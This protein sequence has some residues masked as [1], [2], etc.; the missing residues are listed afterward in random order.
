MLMMPQRDHFIGK[1][2][3]R[4]VCSS[5]YSYQVRSLEPRPPQTCIE[6]RLQICL[7]KGMAIVLLTW[8]SVDGFDWTLL[9]MCGKLIVFFF[10][11]VSTK[12]SAVMLV[13]VL[14]KRRKG[15]CYK[16]SRKGSVLWVI[17]SILNSTIMWHLTQVHKK[18]QIPESRVIN[19]LGYG[20]ESSLYHLWTVSLQ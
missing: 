8:Y 3:S 17:S 16:H 20:F 13:F 10:P 15:I 6:L 11:F 2:K 9:P 19:Q 14:Y 7:L 12:G 4:H 18:K 5:F 1:R